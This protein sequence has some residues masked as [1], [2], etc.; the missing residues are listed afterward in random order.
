M[1]KRTNIQI[2][3]SQFSR[4]I[5]MI[6]ESESDYFKDLLGKSFTSDQITAIR[7]FGGIL[8]DSLE[9]EYDNNLTTIKVSDEQFEDFFSRVASWL[10]RYENNLVKH[11]EKQ[12]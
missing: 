8:E 2:T 11:I 5:D 3:E 1:R 9:M 12:K 6:S 7:E 4:L 10:R